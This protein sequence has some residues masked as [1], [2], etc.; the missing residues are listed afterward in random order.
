MVKKK[1]NI[2]KVNINKVYWTYGLVN[3][4]GKL[5]VAEIYF[6]QLKTK[7][8]YLFFFIPSKLELILNLWRILKDIYAQKKVMKY[9]EWDK[10]KIIIVK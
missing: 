4:E 5:R 7:N 3:F 6:E 9:F 1:V 8:R 2:N 10:D